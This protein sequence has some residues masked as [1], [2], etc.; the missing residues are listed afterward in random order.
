MSGESR[1][2]V[3]SS[4]FISEPYLFVP[5]KSSWGEAL[6]GSRA[7]VK[8]RTSKSEPYLVVSN[9]P[10]LGE[11]LEEAALVS[12][13]QI[14]L[15]LQEQKQYSDLKIGEMLVLRGWISATTVEFFAE[16]W[17]ELLAQKSR[18][19]LGQYLQ[20][21]GLLNAEQITAIL[22]EQDSLWLRFGSLAVLKGWLKER[23]LNF[24]LH[25]LFPDYVYKSA[26]RDK[27][28]NF[29]P[30]PNQPHQ[31]YLPEKKEDSN[32]KSS[33]RHDVIAKETLGEIPWI[34]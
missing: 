12:A 27:Q 33:Q 30:S 5:G 32:I 7:T 9:K 14:S 11:L 31:Q 26:Y 20:R 19:P 16:Q 4:I 3:P 22:R 18:Q 29:A 1:P 2:K 28:N 6:T 25:H 17:T 23:T 10:Y 13:A 21:A 15:T 34:D 8:G 24:F